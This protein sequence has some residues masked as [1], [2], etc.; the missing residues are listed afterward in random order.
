MCAVGLGLLFKNKHYKSSAGVLISSVIRRD[1][2]L[3][4]SGA[5]DLAVLQRGTLTDSAGQ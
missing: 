3:G 4:L 5:G 1:G 2:N